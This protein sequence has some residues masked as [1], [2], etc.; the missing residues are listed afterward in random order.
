MISLIKILKES[1][2]KS[3][4][5]VGTCVNSF[6]EYGE[7]VHNAFYDEQHFFNSWENA[8]KITKEEFWKHIDPESEEYNE[9]KELESDSDYTP[10]YRYSEE[11]DVYFI[12]VG[13]DTHYF[14]TRK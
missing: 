1:T 3:Y 13:D 9:V 11:D 10:E 14:F 6:D 4:E 2:E 5:Y 8:K 12:F 7:C